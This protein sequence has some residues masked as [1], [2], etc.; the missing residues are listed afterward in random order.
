MRGGTGKGTS[1]RR[2]LTAPERRAMIEEAAT[3]LFAEHGYQ[4]TGMND[5][6]RAAGVSVPVVYDH[7]VS[8]QELYRALLEAHYAELRALWARYRGTDVPAEQRIP[9]ALNAWFGYVQSHPFAWRMLFV[10]TT[11]DPAL[12]DVQRQVADTSRQNML[13]LLADELP[14]DLPGV[15]P[16]PALAMA[17]EIVRAGLQGL[18]LW[19]REHPHIAR[20]QVVTMAMNILWIG[21]Q[22]LHHGEH[23]QP[24]K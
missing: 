5:V 10:D 1:Q 24:A 15:D 16:E 21:F 20:D 18:A 9:A 11:G 6:A 4:R 17:W 14:A 7:F 13:P 19:W 23:W 2:R 8:K 22:R 3:R 12:G